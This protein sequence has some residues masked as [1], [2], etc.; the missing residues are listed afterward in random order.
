MKILAAALLVACSATAQLPT[1]SQ[2]LTSTCQTVIVVSNSF[3]CTG[4]RTVS[5]STS[6]SFVD[7]IGTLFTVTD[8]RF[9]LYRQLMLNAGIRH[10]RV[11]GGSDASPAGPTLVPNMQNLA[12]AGIKTQFIVS[13]YNSYS[14]DTAAFW[15]GLGQTTSLVSWIKTTVGAGVI[16]AVEGPN[17]IDNSNEYTLTKW[18]PGDATTLCGTQGCANYFGDFGN[19]IQRSIFTV[20]KA[21]PATASIKVIGPALASVFPNP[22]NYAAGMS[23][24]AYTDYGNCHPYQYAGNFQGGFDPDNYVGFVHYNYQG[25]DPD[26][27]IDEYAYAF[28]WCNGGAGDPTLYGANPLTASE[29]GYFTGT[30]NSAISTTVQAK[31]YPRIYAE[32]FRHG[33]KRTFTYRLED[34]S[35]DLSNGQGNFGIVDY[36]LYPKAAYVAISSLISLLKEPGAS[37]SPATLTYTA[38][39][40]ANGAYTR[41]QYYHDLL[42][43]KSTGEFYLLFWHEATDGQIRAG[44]TGY[45]LLP[46]PS[47]PITP[48]ALPVTLTLPV[49]I[50]S[51]QL[52]TYDANW[53]L[54]PQ[55][56]T[57]TANQVSLQATDTISVLRLS[58]HAPP[59]NSSFNGSL[60]GSFSL[61]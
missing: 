36:T 21:D 47:T 25:N 61:N 9:P 57:I 3:P 56:V 20:I 30:A 51:A 32:A 7:S 43:Q 37:F 58:A 13:T 60:S 42:L 16:D 6:D 53:N 29:S 19:A 52:Y 49:G 17:E 38:A 15:S 44:T 40:S 12:A 46:A 33:M 24:Q 31:Y 14:P 45:P 27:M 48:P 41:T 28:N 8:A 26:N 54:V 34:G 1:V 50:V 23:L 5:A 11:G 2:V 22:L 59:T 10:V 18:H 4:S 55:V 35:S 39:I